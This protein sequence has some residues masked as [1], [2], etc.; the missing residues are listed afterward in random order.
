MVAV[1]LIHIFVQAA[2]FAH[3]HFMKL[4]QKSVFPMAEAH[5]HLQDYCVTVRLAASKLVISARSLSF[6]PFN[7]L[8]TRLNVPLLVSSGAKV[9]TALLFARA[10]D[11]S[12]RWLSKCQS[13]FLVSRICAEWER[14]I[15][16]RL[17][18]HGR[19]WQDYSATQVDTPDAKEE[20]SWSLSDI[21]Q[22][23]ISFTN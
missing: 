22:W 5:H 18:C 3:Q 13:E 11:K 10:A 15:L 2:D 14:I 1:Q 12:L 7:E 20:K 16:N 4:L 19:N 6:L 21:S 23:L 9:L 17:R 8:Q